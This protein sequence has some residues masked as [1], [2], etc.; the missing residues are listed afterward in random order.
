MQGA[1]G[2]V[3]RRRNINTALL[4]STVGAHIFTATSALGCTRT[5]LMYLDNLRIDQMLGFGNF[6]SL[7]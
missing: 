7:S 4:Q 2:L 5:G 3:E 6:R 1:G